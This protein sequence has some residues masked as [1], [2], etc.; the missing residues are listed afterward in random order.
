MIKVKAL[1]PNRIRIDPTWNKVDVKKWEVLEIP[2]KRV[3]FFLM[4]GFVKAE[5]VLKKGE[6]QT[7]DASTKKVRRA[8]GKVK[9][10]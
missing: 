2:K 6:K 4:N 9:A 7:T 8:K 5:D 1:Q 3:T 10:K